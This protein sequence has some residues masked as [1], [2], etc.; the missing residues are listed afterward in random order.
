M[1]GIVGHCR[2]EK[3]DFTIFDLQVDAIRHRGPDDRGAWMNA[4]QEV[5]LG[6]RRLAIVDL[7]IAGH[8]P[9]HLEEEKI[10][11]VFN[12]EIYNYKK[13]RKE[14]QDLGHDFTSDTDTE[15][16]LKSF[17][18]W[19]STFITR[20]KGMFAIALFVENEDT[21]YL[22]R[23]RAGEKPLYYYLDEKGISF[24]SELKC[25]FKDPNFN[26]TL[27]ETGFK[28]YLMYGYT[29]G[30]NT[31]IK[32]VQKLV[33]GNFLTFDRSTNKIQIE[34]YWTLPPNSHSAEVTEQELIQKASTLLEAAV[35][36][37]LHA[38]V[39]LGILLSGGLDSS[40]MTAFAAK[41]TKEKVKTFHISFPGHGKYNESEY[42]R[43]VSKYFNTEHHDLDG[44]VMKPEL[45]DD[46]L[47]FI[48]EP[49]ADSS[50]LPTY[51]VS[52][53]TRQYVTVALGGDG[54]DELFG[55]YTKYEK[56]LHKNGKGGSGFIKNLIAQLPTGFRSKNFA[57]EKLMNAFDV[58]Q[59]PAFFY[60]QDMLHI[61]SK[62]FAQKFRK[63]KFPYKNPKKYN[64][65]NTIDVFTRLDF[66]T[67]LPDD[68]IV[69]VDRMSMAH[70]LEVRAPFLDKDVI[71]FAFSS[72]P[73]N[74]KISSDG[75]K[76]VLL[77]KVGATILPPDLDLER[78]Q[79]F[80][81]PLKSWMNTYWNNYFKSAIEEIDSAIFSKVAVQQLLEREKSNYFNNSHRIFAIVLLDKWIKK[82]NI[83]IQ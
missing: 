59:N 45:I 64:I 32:N 15:V 17:S 70:S 73:S 33:P 79:G 8:M 52:K 4:S 19:G 36:S 80:S 62:D 18:Q 74:Q 58:M 46:I 48:D 39:P 69:K 50:L 43:K 12:G 75:R 21:L 77:K 22:Y 55:G 63:D 54:G 24:A 57:Q 35:V 60:P 81:I 14:L 68:V 49:I 13:V 5:A 31:L 44:G 61:L 6:S 56:V 76:K 71:E 9:M 37:Q 20:L 25:F 51:L 11:L 78:K 3:I 2:T 42:A 41:N 38:D 72:V 83:G 34:Q 82:Y 40:L 26:P 65:E 66:H 30:E 53:L 7:S 67:Y 10:H 16:I 27:D 47:D 29:I 23:D 1:C 28:Q